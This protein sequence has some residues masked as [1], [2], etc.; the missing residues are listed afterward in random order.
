[1]RYLNRDYLLQMLSHSFC[2]LCQ[3]ILY[4]HAVLYVYLTK[5]ELLSANHF[6]DSLDQRSDTDIIKICSVHHELF[7]NATTHLH[8]H[9]RAHTHTHRFLQSQKEGNVKTKCQNC[10]SA[11][12]L[13]DPAFEQLNDV[14][15]ELFQTRVLPCGKH[16][17][18]LLLLDGLLKTQS[19]KLS[20]ET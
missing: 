10:H 11:S 20:W 13:K 14:L 8:T 18:V 12:Y 17:D 5:T 6:L 1:M 3:P 9:T 2:E 7:A 4:T 19:I 15:H 16:L